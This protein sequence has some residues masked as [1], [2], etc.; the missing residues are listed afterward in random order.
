LGRGNLCNPFFF[1]PRK[2]RQK[3]IQ[4]TKKCIKRRNLS[5]FPQHSTVFA[6]FWD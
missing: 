4:T 6:F 2:P 3:S 1:G 5:Q